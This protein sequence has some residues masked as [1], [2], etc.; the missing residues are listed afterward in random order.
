MTSLDLSSSRKTSDF[1]STQGFSL[2]LFL[3]T[4]QA[5]MWGIWKKYMCFFSAGCTG[6]GGLLNST[7]RLLSQCRHSESTL[8]FANTKTWRL[9]KSIIFPLYFCKTTQS[10][11]FFR[12]SW[13]GKRCHR[14]VSLIFD[15]TLGETEKKMWAA[16]MFSL[17]IHMLG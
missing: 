5:I 2:L 10:Y 17:K 8:N 11:L 13:R 1:L 7:A 14:C 3:V 12:W 9:A 4:L 6:F 15:V 16:C